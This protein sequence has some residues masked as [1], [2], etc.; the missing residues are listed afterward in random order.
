MAHAATI[1]FRDGKTSHIEVRPNELLME[2]ARRQGVQ[3]P[4]DCREGVCA[5][6]RGVCESGVI[7]QDYVDD[8]A[9]TPAELAKGHMLACQ[10]RLKSNGTF[11]FDVDSSIS[12]ISTKIYHA[13]VSAVEPVSEAAAILELSLDD[14]GKKLKF[15]PGQYARIQVP[16]TD[17]W[18][19]Y[20][21]ANA[22]AVEGKLRFLIRLLPSGVMSDYVR[23]R[24]KVGDAIQLEAP[25]GVFYLRTIRRP[26]VMVAG[27][28]GLSAFLA[29]L[30]AMVVQ[31]GCGQPIQLYYGVNYEAD[32]SEL[33]RLAHY[34]EQ[35]AEFDYH[36]AVLHP[37]SQWQGNQGVVCDMFD[38]SFLQHPFDAYL[39]GPPGMIEATKAWLR[40]K[41]VAEY[42]LFFEKFVSS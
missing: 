40:D 14:Q 7:E 41:P 4:V 10:T 2:A 31:G 34:K 21:F 26:L 38:V 3:L 9:L 32:L 5:T 22:S 20:S 19:A 23:Q 29:M 11:Y 36:I 42:Q 25:L 39:C 16:N 27:G 1:V 13:T 37:S 33:Q 15:L 30:D 12:S 18:R 17:Q 28:T 35:L 6:C 8:E 24:A